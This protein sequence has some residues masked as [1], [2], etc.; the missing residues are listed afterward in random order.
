MATDKEIEAA[1]EAISEYHSGNAAEG[2]RIVKAA[3]EA[4]EA[5][6]SEETKANN[7]RKCKGCNKDI[8]HKH[9]NAKFC[10]SRCKDKFWNTINPR[11]M[12]VRQ[13]SEGYDPDDDF[14]PS[15]DS[16]KDTF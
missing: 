1:L 9:P 15:W 5:V 13:E 16:H 11:G 14:D 4:A 6:R 2:N 10:K 12:A 8:S 3:L 7:K